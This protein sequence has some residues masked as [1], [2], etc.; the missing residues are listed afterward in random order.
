MKDLPLYLWIFFM[1][2]ST[3]KKTPVLI[4][5]CGEQLIIESPLLPLVIS[6]VALLP[7]FYDSGWSCTAAECFVYRVVQQIEIDGQSCE[8]AAIRFYYKTTKDEFGFIIERGLMPNGIITHHFAFGWAPGQKRGQSSFLVQMNNLLHN[9]AAQSFQPREIVITFLDG[10]KITF[11]CFGSAG[12]YY[13]SA[14]ESTMAAD[15]Y[16]SWLRGIEIIE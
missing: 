11:C 4:P 2:C 6:P 7:D 9:Q 1:G 5:F 12:G 10:S 15:I 8:N 14:D 3:P 13:L 16:D